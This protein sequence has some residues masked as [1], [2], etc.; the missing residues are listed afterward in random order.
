[1]E[2]NLLDFAG[3][4]ERAGFRLWRFEVLNW[5]TFDH[6]V[7]KMDIEGHNALLTGDIGSG[8]STLVDALTT[9]LVS[10]Q[11][12][13]YNQA[14]G[15]TTRER[16]LGSY[17]R[18]AYKTEKD[19]SQFAAKAVHLRKEGSY[20]VLLGYFFNEGY[21]TGV[22]LMQVFWAREGQTQ[23]ERF[24]A[25][26]PGSMSIAGDLG[27]FKSIADLKK[28]LR[29]RPDMIL[30]DSFAR[31][32]AEFRRRMDI[33]SE[34]AMDLF[35]KTVSMKAVGNLTEFVRSHMLE[36][37]PVRVR[38]EEMCRDFENLNRAHESV[39]KARDQIGWL[40]PL[41]EEC[42]RLVEV[43]RNNAG[44]HR[45]REALHAYFSGQ[46]ADLLDKWIVQKDSEH[47][48][49]MDYLLRK[50]ELQGTLRAR[51]EELQRSIAESGGG[52]LE[53]LAQDIVRLTEEKD[54]REE[55]SREYAR[56]CRAVKLPDASGMEAFHANREKAKALETAMDT[57]RRQ[58]EDARV[59]VQVALTKMKENAGRLD[60]EIASLRARRWRSRRRT[61]RLPESFC[62]CVPEPRNGKGPWNACC[63]TLA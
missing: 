61:C 13:T 49:L 2:T 11:R 42:D 4:D 53:R 34:Q 57:R 45:C 16:T 14:A 23:P 22:T 38:V 8:K 29:K 36:E 12:I 56:F 17:V 50:K 35:Y 26:V 60:V 54:R 21:Q 30:E 10:P 43:G 44:L 41:V 24:Y 3:T 52:R 40:V 19:E 46:W 47:E 62:R 33:R 20:S 25:V 37:P 55:R 58:K 9:L 63:T 32:A 1:M 39:L 59:D 18:G 6:H 28:R 31:Y 48:K 27:H 15:A 7:W 51:Q 5:G